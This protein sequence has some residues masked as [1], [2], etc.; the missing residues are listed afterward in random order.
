MLDG[1]LIKRF[2]HHLTGR[3]L[4]RSIASPTTLVLPTLT[5][6]LQ[7]LILLLIEPL[8]KFSILFNA[9]FEKTPPLQQL[10][11][12]HH[13]PLCSHLLLESFNRQSGCS[14]PR[15][16]PLHTHYSFVT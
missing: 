1:T 13:F 3:L 16:Q 5:N 14:F 2:S 10:F 15:K 7:D 9:L 12:F 11:M 4:I 8:D 6:L